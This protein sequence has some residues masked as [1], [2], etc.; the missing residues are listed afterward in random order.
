MDDFYH[1]DRSFIQLISDAILFYKTSEEFNDI[2]KGQSFARASIL[3]S[4]LSLEA[5]ANNCLYEIKAPKQFTNDFERTTT[6]C[7]FDFYAKAHK[8]K[9]IDRGCHAFQGVSK[10]KTLRDSTVHPKNNRI[11]LEL[12][13]DE[14]KYQ[15][16]IELGFLL[17]AKPCPVT[18]IDKNSIFW[19]SKDA[20]SALKLVFKFYDYYFVDLLKLSSIERLQLLC[21][22][23]VMGDQ[24]WIFHHD[25]VYQA[26]ENLHKIG[27][28]QQTIDFKAMPKLNTV[29]PEDA[30]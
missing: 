10:L 3:N 27:I 18:Q 16:Y 30:R 20:K 9:F 6:F 29:N 24:A 2:Y 26:F 14:D 25:D 4:V 19:L 12:S 13:L 17:D 7:K 8:G 11:P 21:N 23:M 15:N 5:A 1:Y 28:T 22:S